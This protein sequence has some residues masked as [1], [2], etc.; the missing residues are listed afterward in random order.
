MP[1]LKTNRCE[2]CPALQG[3]LNLNL[4]KL[5]ISCLKIV[6]RCFILVMVADGN[7]GDRRDD[8]GDGDGGAGSPDGDEPAVQASVL[9][10]HCQLSAASWSWSPRLPRLRP[11]G[12]FRPVPCLG[13][14]CS[15]TRVLGS[16]AGSQ[17]IR[18]PLGHQLC[19]SMRAFC[20]LGF[21]REKGSAVQ[22]VKPAAHKS[23]NQV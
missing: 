6:T 20:C 10:C 23:P 3:I 22:P 4:A 9:R 13:A 12:G 19:H 14:Q 11:S 21:K 16:L 18:S 8:E 5:R 1:H 15:A 2:E 7:A 17:P